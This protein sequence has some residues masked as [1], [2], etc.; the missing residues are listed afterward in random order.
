MDWGQDAGCVGRPVMESMCVSIREW[1]GVER[2]AV[3]ETEDDESSI[4]LTWGP[5][6]RGVNK[7]Y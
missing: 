2:R 3:G 6:L 5:A 7:L 4:L 1:L